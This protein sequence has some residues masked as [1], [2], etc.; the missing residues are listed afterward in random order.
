MGMPRATW[1]LTLLQ[2]SAS[3]LALS[4]GPVR[5]LFNLS[6]LGRARRRL[7]LSTTCLS[8]R[9]LSFY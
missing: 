5:V 2:A 8:Q 6:R 7:T 4:R 9:N 3:G 1:F